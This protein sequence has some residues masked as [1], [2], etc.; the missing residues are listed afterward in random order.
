MF[1]KSMVFKT[2]IFLENSELWTIEADKNSAAQSRL[3]S[4]ASNSTAG[5]KAA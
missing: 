2:I 5:M 1:I 3:I 4:M